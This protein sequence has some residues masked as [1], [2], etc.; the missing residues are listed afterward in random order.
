M[1]YNHVP[2]LKWDDKGILALI[3]IPSIT[4]GTYQETKRAAPVPS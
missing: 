2:S 3:L 1:I 4:G